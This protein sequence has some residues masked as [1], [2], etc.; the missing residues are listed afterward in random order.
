MA[1][2]FL[3]RIGFQSS[4]DQLKLITISK[5]KNQIAGE[6]SAGVQTVDDSAG[7]SRVP[8]GANGDNS[9]KTNPRER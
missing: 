1:D 8:V 6:E 9:K 3:T 7:D 2:W 4:T 5:T